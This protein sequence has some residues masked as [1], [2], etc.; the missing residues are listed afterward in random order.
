MAYNTKLEDD[1]TQ[2]ERNCTAKY[3]QLKRALSSL[4]ESLDV[5]SKQS[6]ALADLS[7]ISVYDDDSVYKMITDDPVLKVSRSI[8]NSDSFIYLQ[9]ILK[10]EGISTMSYGKVA[11]PVITDPQ[12]KNMLAQKFSKQHAQNTAGLCQDIRL[13]FIGSFFLK[14]FISILLLRKFP[15]STNDVLLSTEQKIFTSDNLLSWYTSAG[16]D[17]SGSP[18]H[19]NEAKIAYFKKYIG[20]LVLDNIACGYLHV[21]DWLGALLENDLKIVEPTMSYESSFVKHKR[22]LIDY[23]KSK[24]PEHTIA[25]IERVNDDAFDIEVKVGGI[26]LARCKNNSRDLAEENASMKAIQEI[27]YSNEYAEYKNILDR[28]LFSDINAMLESAPKKRISEAGKSDAQNSRKK[29]KQM[30]KVSQAASSFERRISK[31]DIRQNLNKRTL[32]CALDEADYDRASDSTYDT[33]SKILSDTTSINKSNLAH[34]FGGNEDKINSIS[35]GSPDKA[36]SSNL[37]EDNYVNINGSKT[38]YVHVKRLNDNYANKP[39][40]SNISSVS[41]PD[42]SAA[43]SG[44]V[45]NLAK[46]SIPPNT[47]A[48]G[49]YNVK[50]IVGNVSSI[51]A[52]ETISA[53]SEKDVINTSLRKGNYLIAGSHSGHLA[54]TGGAENITTIESV[55]NTVAGVNTPNVVEVQTDTIITG[56]DI[57]KQTANIGSAPSLN[58]EGNADKHPNATKLVF[59]KSSKQKLHSL[60]GKLKDHPRY[61]TAHH[62]KTHF[63]SRCFTVGGNMLLGTGAGK[64][65]QIAEQKA[66]SDALHKLL[67]RDP[68]QPKKKN[69]IYL[70]RAPHEV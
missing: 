24:F 51:S 28:V 16:F 15:N 20:G 39:H 38:D 32:N 31:I 67:A 68:P 50:A 69:N 21:I 5:I 52:K 41:S 48:E 22:K 33:E 34:K 35:H 19:S 64:S 11:C 55:Y 53:P 3:W 8:K 23:V 4:R 1:Y 59:D 63:I 26:T 45:G 13:E 27:A 70:N 57:I 56:N 40:N 42:N 37:V 9:Q 44:N 49:K 65:K 47:L 43:K 58:T 54:R 60:L 30:K 2:W 17:K 18:F 66:A 6:F 61:E 14:L 12:L 36:I 29:A 25:S 62:T 7:K 10:E 46:I